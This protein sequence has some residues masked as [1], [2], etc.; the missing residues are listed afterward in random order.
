[1]KTKLKNKFFPVSIFSI[2]ITSC[3]L[4]CLF[5]VCNILNYSLLIPLFLFF[6]SIQ[7]KFILK[8]NYRIFLNLGLLLVVIVSISFLASSYPE[9]SYFYI[10]A[11]GIAMLTMLLFDNI[12]LSFVMSVAVSVLLGLILKLDAGTI[13]TLFLGCITGAYSVKGARRRDQLIGAGLFVSVVHLVCLYL[14]HP[15]VKLLL[16]P[17]FNKFSLYPMVASGFISTFFVAATLKIFEYLFGV[18]TNYSLLELSDFNQP[19]LRRMILEAPGTYQ[20]SLVVS[21]L[22]EAAADSIGANSLLT[23]VGAYYHD[24]G[25]M[26]KPVYFTENQQLGRN[27]HDDMEPSMSRLVI[28]NHVKDGIELAKKNKLNQMIIDFIPQHHGTSLMHFFY[29]KALEDADNSNVVES[30]FRYP[31]PK[32][33]SRE[34]A[35]TMLAD[36]V[37]AAVRSLDEATPSRIEETVKKVVNNKF[38]DGQLDECNLTLKEIEKISSTFIRFL[39]A[40]YHGR[41]KYPEK[42]NETH[43]RES[44]EKNTSQSS[45]DS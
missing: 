14:M 29:Q 15:N 2:V 38:I 34:T 18:L 28:L 10:P 41:V 5:L 7:L 6:L 45:K 37:E 25:K 4:L 31:G 3:V 23:R 32:P 16:E 13:T 42:N 17:G 44:S 20:H 12:N 27:R 43:S 1:M 30:D 35:I 8:S 36:S 19:L 26:I 39:S 21:N 40:M 9:I 33:Q 11:A 22:A 24:V